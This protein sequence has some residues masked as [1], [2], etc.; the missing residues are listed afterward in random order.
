MTFII[1][2]LT[3]SFHKDEKKRRKTLINTARE[4]SSGTFWI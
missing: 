4:L 1:K 2:N 3:M